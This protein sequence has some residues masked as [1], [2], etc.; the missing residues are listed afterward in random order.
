MKEYIPVL[1]IWL[2]IVII[3][4]FWYAVGS[5]NWIINI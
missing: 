3:F 1:I 4:M 5:I 2:M